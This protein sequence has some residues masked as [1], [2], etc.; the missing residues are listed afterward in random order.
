MS[1][2]IYDVE[3]TKNYEGIRSTNEPTVRQ[4][5]V[6][7]MICEEYPALRELDT[8]FT[9]QAYYNFISEWGVYCKKVKINFY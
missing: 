8:P 2:K 1:N 9:R 3:G 6:Y 4:Q 7:E 5:N